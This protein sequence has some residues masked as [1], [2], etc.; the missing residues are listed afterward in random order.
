LNLGN[1][2]RVTSPS[3][4]FCLFLLLSIFYSP[5]V[6]RAQPPP[7]QSTAQSTSQIAYPDT[8]AGLKQLASDIVK[9]Q[10]ENNSAHAGELL[11]SFILPNFAEWYPQNFSES[12][13]ARVVP[14]Y[15]AGATSL[16]FQLAGIFIDN[17]QAGFRKIEAMRYE[18]EESACS[19]GP[20]FAAMTA[21]K[22]HIPLYELRFING[23]QLK[24]LF[25]FAYVDG[26]F[27]L[28]LVPDFSKPMPGAASPAEISNPKNPTANE[29]I[30]MGAAVQAAKLV[31]RVQPYYPEEARH[32][33]ISGT[34]RF[35]TIIGK[36]GNI[37]QLEILSGHPILATAAQQAVSHWRY[38]PTM[39]DGEPVEVDTTIDVIFSLSE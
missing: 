24:R 38:H 11:H 16:P 12:A 29:R 33:R 36:D 37:K 4:S 35:H 39:I 20:I 10:R 13:S 19:S 14:A 17:F 8:T 3:Y 34:V 28:V 31:C 18:N 1:Y 26:A 9:A 25:A 15:T 30:A 5:A 7:P 21:R 22:S 23:D 27:R 32:Q 2:A 6:L